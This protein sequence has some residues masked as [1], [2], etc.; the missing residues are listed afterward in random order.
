M[1]RAERRSRNRAAHAVRRE[2]ALK[3]WREARERGDGVTF[4][5]VWEVYAGTP[6]DVVLATLAPALAPVPVE[7]VAVPETAPRRRQAPGHVR[8][9]KRLFDEANAAWLAGLEV[10]MAGGRRDGRPARGERW[11][12]EERDYRAAH[13]A[14]QYAEILSQVCAERRGLAHEAEMAAA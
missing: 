8:E 1:T 3:D 5:Q 2:L 4:G 9:A 6:V 12:D 7:P 14:P 13:R 11:T 10:A